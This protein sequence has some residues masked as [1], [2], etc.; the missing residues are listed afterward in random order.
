VAG[1]WRRLVDREGAAKDAEVDLTLVVLCLW[2]LVLTY[3]GGA[4]NSKAML[5]GSR[6]DSPE[7]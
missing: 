7:P 6:K 4:K 1:H 5:S 3:P 2:A